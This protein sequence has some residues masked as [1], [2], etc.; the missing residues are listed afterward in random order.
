M[1]LDIYVW[2]RKGGVKIHERVREV[3]FIDLTY[4]NNSTIHTYT[5][6]HTFF[7]ILSCVPIFDRCFDS[8]TANETIRRYL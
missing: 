6:T 3:R 8:L 2:R 5:H 1:L 4:E 7:A